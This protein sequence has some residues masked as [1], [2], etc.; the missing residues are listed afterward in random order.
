MD[1][2]DIPMTRAERLII[3]E[4]ITLGKK[5]DTILE[6]KVYESIDEISLRK[7]SKILRRGSGTIIRLVEAG[8][9]RALTYKDAEHKTR[10][11]FRVA[12][13]REYQ[14]KGQTKIEDDFSGVETTEQIAERIFGYS[15][16]RRK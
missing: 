11:R 15:P 13:I 6:D 7:A 5:I 9:L 2:K 4:L 1:N 3:D 16:K 14:K 8:K 10:Y 12:D